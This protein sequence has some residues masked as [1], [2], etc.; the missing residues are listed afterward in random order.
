MLALG[1]AAVKAAIHRGRSRLR[2]LSSARRE[3]HEDASLRPSPTVSR[4]ATLFNARDWDGIRAMLAEDVRLDV[5]S[6]MQRSGRKSVGS[7]FSNYGRL[8]W[9]RVV[10]A[11]VDE[12]EALVFFRHEGDSRPAHVVELTVD[13]NRI[14]RIRD[15]LHV[16]YVLQDAEVRP[17][18]ES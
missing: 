14:T 3:A 1:E 2:Q 10:P 6:R 5:V 17:A 12:R 16:E 15:F 13:E 8:S 7:Y 11:W 18:A 4:Y 9:W